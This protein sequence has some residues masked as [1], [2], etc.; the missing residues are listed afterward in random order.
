MWHVNKPYLLNGHDRVSSIY[1][2]CRS[3]FAAGARGMIPQRNKRKALSLTVSLYYIWSPVLREFLSTMYVQIKNHAYNHVY[4]FLRKRTKIF[5]TSMHIFS[6][7]VQVR[8][9]GTTPVLGPK[10]MIHVPYIYACGIH[11]S[12]TLRELKTGLFKIIPCG[13]FRWG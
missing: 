3:K 9:I 11:V 1:Y 2:I 5:A 13:P 10:C 7:K 4:A 12:Y 8:S 6:A